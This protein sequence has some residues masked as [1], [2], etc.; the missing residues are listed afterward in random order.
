MVIETKSPLCFQPGVST[1]TQVWVH[2]PRCEG[3]RA[4]AQAAWWNFHYL[5]FDIV[6]WYSVPTT[7]EQKGMSACTWAWALV[8]WRE[9]KPKCFEPGMTACGQSF[10]IPTTCECRELHF[11]KIPAV[12]VWVSHHLRLSLPLNLKAFLS[13]KII[14]RSLP[15]HKMLGQKAKYNHEPATNNKNFITHSHFCY[16]LEVLSENLKVTIANFGIKCRISW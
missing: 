16:C 7:F 2:V 8:P 10:Y 5:I 4:C 12:R 6:F 1:C 13:K 3:I 15:P 9:C 14:C 11:W